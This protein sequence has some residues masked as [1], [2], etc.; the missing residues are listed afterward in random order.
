MSKDTVR[1]I[2][3]GLLGIALLVY[4]IFLAGIVGTF[5]ATQI[6]NASIGIVLFWTVLAFI[7]IFFFYEIYLLLSI[8]WAKRCRKDCGGL[9][10]NLE[11]STEQIHNGNGGKLVGEIACIRKKMKSHVEDLG[12]ANLNDHFRH[13]QELSGL[14]VRLDQKIENARQNREQRDEL[15]RAILEDADFNDLRKYFDELTGSICAIRASIAKKG[16][17][18]R[19]LRVGWYIG[20]L[21]AVSALVA[22][23]LNS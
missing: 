3:V 21:I 10:E 2:V 22:V 5:V 16:T 13:Y 20:V 6:G 9:C 4:A 23:A 19:N 8:Q 7:G 15:C 17:E 11:R 14:L 1:S 18:S 12:C